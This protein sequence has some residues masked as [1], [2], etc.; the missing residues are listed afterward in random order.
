MVVVGHWTRNDC[1]PATPITPQTRTREKQ[2]G[3]SF[4]MTVWPPYYLRALTAP[5]MVSDGLHQQFRTAPRTVFAR[6]PP[7]TIASSGGGLGE[8]SR[9]VRI[10]LALRLFAPVRSVPTH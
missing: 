5:G 8:T 1:A 4:L 7:G 10:S 9:S 3:K 6:V 2:I